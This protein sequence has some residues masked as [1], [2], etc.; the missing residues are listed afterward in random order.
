VTS[1]LLAQVHG[2]STDGTCVI[3]VQHWSPGTLLTY[4]NGVRAGTERGTRER[5]T[6]RF[7][8]AQEALAPTELTDAQAR[9]K[10]RELARV[11]PSDCRCGKQLPVGEHRCVRC[12]LSQG[13]HA[14]GTLSGAYRRPP[15]VLRVSS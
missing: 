15:I 5:I 7:T 1:R 4:R 13:Q 10:L 6:G 8:Q 12:G 3:T 2:L 9:D 14:A 11:E